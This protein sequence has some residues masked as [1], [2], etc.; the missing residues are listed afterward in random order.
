MLFFYYLLFDY[1]IPVLVAVPHWTP[2][3]GPD[4]TPDL[5][6]YPDPD[7]PFHLPDPD[8]VPV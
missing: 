8:P 7:Y 1:L 4:L 2:D 5:T 3:P 6:L